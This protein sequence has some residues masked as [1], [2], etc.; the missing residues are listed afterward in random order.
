MYHIY[1]LHSEVFDSFLH[2]FAFYMQQK[3][4]YQKMLILYQITLIERFFYIYIQLFMF[5]LWDVNACSFTAA[6]VYDSLFI[7]SGAVIS[8]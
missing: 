2:P 5:I 6:V 1:G 8:L 7:M 3:S 4:L